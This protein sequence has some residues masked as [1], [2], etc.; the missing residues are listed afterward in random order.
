M[1]IENS[2]NQDIESIFSLYRLATAFQKTK[3]E[4]NVW[5]EFDRVTVETEINENRQFKLLIDNRIA[6]VWAVTFTDPLIWPQKNKDPSIYI[7]RIATNPDFRGYYFVKTI[8]DW[9]RVY[10]TKNKKRFIRLDTCGNNKNLISYY[11]K[12]GFTFLGINKL[13]DFKRLPSHYHSADVCYFEI[14][15]HVS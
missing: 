10:A 1:H 14:D 13:K 12:C 4:G 5:P 3:F 7:H 8:V 15:L 9:A 6:C 2:T 11:I